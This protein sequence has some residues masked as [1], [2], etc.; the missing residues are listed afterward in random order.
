MSDSALNPS[1]PSYAPT[2]LR[3]IVDLVVTL[4]VW[5]Y[6]TL[7]FVIC[8]S[9]IYLAGYL[10]SKNREVFFQRWNHIFFKAFF[11]LIRLLIPGQSWQISPEI[12]NIR[13]AVIV[14]NHLSY[15]DPLLMI[16]LFARHKTIVKERFFQVPIFSWVLK[17][18]GYLPATADRRNPELWMEQVRSLERYLAAGGN[19]FVFPEGTRSRNGHIGYINRGAFKIARFCRAPIVVLFI[20]HTE[21]LFPPGK[22]SL[23]TAAKNTISINLLEHIQP[24]F[25]DQTFVMGD[26]VSRVHSILEKKAIRL[27]R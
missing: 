6:F 17:H 10:F 4:V 2:C 26:L 1:S 16:S 9:P 5:V 20:T 23:N 3:S 24:D 19:L 7:G 18:S 11:A 27:L 14:C 12:R 21:A 25:Q 13:G 15:L 22:F 8:F